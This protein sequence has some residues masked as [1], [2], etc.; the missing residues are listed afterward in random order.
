[1]VFARIRGRFHWDLWV[2]EQTCC[3]DEVGCSG[4]EHG[5]KRDF[6]EGKRNNAVLGVFLN[7]I[8][9]SNKGILVTLHPKTTSL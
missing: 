9:Y 6:V 1:V 3:W 8:F 7:F 5:K 4:K 2:K